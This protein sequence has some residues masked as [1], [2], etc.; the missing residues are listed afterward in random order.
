ME[1]IRWT[2]DENQVQIGRKYLPTASFFEEKRKLVSSGTTVL[3]LGERGEEHR[4]GL[5][6]DGKNIIYVP[7]G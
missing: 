7:G 4:S 3:A 2:S 6:R 1:S 5:F